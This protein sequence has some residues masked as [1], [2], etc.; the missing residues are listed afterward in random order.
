MLLHMNT[1][2]RQTQSKHILHTT[3]QTSDIVQSSPAGA[4]PAFYIEIPACSNHRVSPTAKRETQEAAV[5]EESPNSTLCP[6][7]HSRPE[8]GI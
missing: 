8:F 3:Q 7:F 1:R 2:G 5:S 6:I 4:T